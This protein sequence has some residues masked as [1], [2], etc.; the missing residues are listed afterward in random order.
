MNDTSTTGEFPGSWA[1]ARAHLI[2]AMTHVPRPTGSSEADTAFD[3]FSHFLKRH[4]L[5][6]AL[7]IAIVL[8]DLAVAPRAFWVELLAAARTMELSDQV[9]L[10]SARVGI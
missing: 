6:P 3:D 7:G 2:A 5:E 1:A 8:G 9:M 10:I 4:E